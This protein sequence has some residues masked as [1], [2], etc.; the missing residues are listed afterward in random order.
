LPPYYP[1]GSRHVYY[2]YGSHDLTI[3]G[4]LAA[5]IQ[6]GGGRRE[7]GGGRRRRREE[8]GGALDESIG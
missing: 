3:G 2:H 4:N 6:Q 5:P 1:M 8:E 7:K